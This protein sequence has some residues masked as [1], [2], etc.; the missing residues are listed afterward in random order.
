MNKKPK[1]CLIISS[2]PPAHS[3]GLGQ[4]IIDA[5]EEANIEV[6]FLTRYIEN[7]NDRKIIGVRQLP[8]SLKYKKLYNSIIGRIIRK[9]YHYIKPFKSPYIINNNIEIKYINEANPTFPIDDVV[10]KIK[11]KYDLVITLFWQDMIN[12]STLRVIYEKLHCP[13]LMYSP[14]M[15]P[16]TGGCFYFGKCNNYKRECGECP[17]LNSSNLYDQSHTNY[18]IKRDNYLNSN[19]AFLGNTWMNE[20]FRESSLGWCCKNYNVGIVLDENEFLYKKTERTKLRKSIGIG[21]NDFVVMLRSTSDI[22]KGN[23]DILR[24][25]ILLNKSNNKRKIMIITVGDRYF[26]NI[27]SKY[28]IAVLDKGYAST[29]DLINLYNVTDV[30]I[31]ASTDD[32]GPSMI[33]QSLMCGTPVI[34]YDTGVALD[35]VIENLSGVRVKKGNIQAL[36]AGISQIMVLEEE[37]YEELRDNSRKVAYARNSKLCFANN[38]IEIYNDMIK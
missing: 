17:G 24:S 29:F 26:Y 37:K 28:D 34:S 10:S 35:V 33:N 23:D 22:R 1:K 14:D 9:L 4:N 5:L 38:I 13:I 2:R 12:T 18:L 27:A 16:M 15:S 20:R 30:F 7:K 8:F 3:A 19:I 21:S 11:K 6:D 31:S 32:A 25:I 36:A